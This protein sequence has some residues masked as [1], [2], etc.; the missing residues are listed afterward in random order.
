[1]RLVD[2]MKNQKEFP[3]FVLSRSTNGKQASRQGSIRPIRR[4]DNESA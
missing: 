3:H 1:M 4:E 2:H